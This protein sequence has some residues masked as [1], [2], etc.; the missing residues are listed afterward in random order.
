MRTV[1]RALTLLSLAV[2]A[3]SCGG[4]GTS[5]PA[6]CQGLALV[7]PDHPFYEDPILVP[8]PQ[9]LNRLAQQACARAGAPEDVNRFLFGAAPGVVF[10]EM[11]SRGSDVRRLDVA[12]R[13]WVLYLSGYFGGVWLRGEIVAAQPDS[14]LAGFGTV[15]DRDAFLETTD[16][17]RPAV[18]AVSGS[19]RD[20]IAYSRG[21]R[22]EL[23]D[24]FG[25][26]K[27]YLLQILED[28]PAGLT[29]PADL[30]HCFGPLD[31]RYEPLALPAL[32]DYAHVPG[33]LADPPDAAWAEVAAGLPELQDAAERRGRSVWS[34]GLS[35]QGFSQ[36][37]YEILL[38]VSAAFLEAV[39]ATTLANLEAAAESD[40]AL[41]RQGAA[42]DA[43][44]RIWIGSYTMGLLDPRNDRSLP[45]YEIR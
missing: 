43:A 1:A 36:D 14:L 25:Y 33:L 22:D 20:A 24:G 35:V 2:V 6:Q 11:L 41:A 40:G 39:Q 44:F 27:G 42:A 15:P 5:L 9:E 28:P 38:D 31:C 12:R 16:D 29:S 7:V 3:A 18:A 26:N 21:A 34:S 10:D 8:D 30:L 32:L 37:S 23:V 19:D 4:D 45:S 13:L 17:A